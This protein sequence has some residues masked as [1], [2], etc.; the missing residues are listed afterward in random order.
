MSVLDC[1][2]GFQVI[3]PC[4]RRQIA[5]HAVKQLCKCLYFICYRVS[6]V[7]RMVSSAIWMEHA[8]VHEFFKEHR[9]STS[10]KDECNLRSLKNSRVHVLSKFYEYT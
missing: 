6:I 2:A 3:D 9:N 5:T 10:P 4:T 7:N 1:Q 8:Q